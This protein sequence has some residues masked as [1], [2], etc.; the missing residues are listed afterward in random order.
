M[1]GLAGRLKYC[2]KG[3]GILIT[4][5]SEL[6]FYLSVLNQHLPI[7][8]QLLPKLAENLNAEIVLNTI[9]TV[10]DA[11]EWL[12][13]TYLYIRM[14]SEQSLYGCS[15]DERK[16]EPKLEQSFI[17]L[18]NTAACQLDKTNLI[19]YDRKSGVFQSTDLGRIAS[20][21]YC[22]NETMSSYNVL[23]KPTMSEIELFRVFSLSAEFR[24]LR[25]R[26][27]DKLELSKLLQRVPIP[28]V[29]K[30]GIDEPSAK[31]NLLL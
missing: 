17:D 27:E 20:H 25:V 9:Q 6:P 8:S 29:S 13:H 30:A 18:I 3:V 15:N 2:P 24:N 26:D 10:R 28:E 14:L 5:H 4:S 7:E 1:L 31:C 22:S 23:M 11:V 19:R 21:H 16:T 12:M